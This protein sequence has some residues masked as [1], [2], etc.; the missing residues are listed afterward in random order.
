MVSLDD[1][2]PYGDIV[3]CAIP[4]SDF[5]I[6]MP[7]NVDHHDGSFEAKRAYTEYLEARKAQ[8]QKESRKARQARQA[9][10]ARD[11]SEYVKVMTTLMWMSTPLFHTS[12]FAYAA[13]I[14]PRLKGL[15]QAVQDT[16][17]PHLVVEAEASGILDMSGGC[18]TLGP[19]EED[20]FSSPDESM[21]GLVRNVSK[22]RNACSKHGIPPVSNIEVLHVLIGERIGFYKNG[23]RGY[24]DECA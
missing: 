1:E 19:L 7:H 21:R 22:Y 14:A 3:A 8:E 12:E 23:G 17:K 11:R 2:A 24:C 5:V 15:F 20:G 13:S 16:L 4:G 9:R 6:V 18:V 10:Q